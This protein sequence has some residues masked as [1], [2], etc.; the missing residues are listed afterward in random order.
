MNEQQRRAL[1][2]ERCEP[3]DHDRVE[4][5]ERRGNLHGRHHA[6]VG[7]QRVE[8]IVT[9]GGASVH[10]RSQHLV[11]LVCAERIGL[12]PRLGPV[13]RSV[14]AH[15][16]EMRRDRGDLTREVIRREPPLPESIG[17]R[18][19]RGDDLHSLPDHRAEEGHR[20]QRLGDV[21]ELELV[22]AEQAVRRE[23]VDRL[24]HAEEADDAGQ[25]GER[26]VRLRV[27]AS[28]HA[29]ASRWVLPTP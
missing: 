8:L 22:D 19:R 12:D 28:C 21:V 13:V 1:V 16:L 23:R 18:V 4:A 15:D 5:L 14:D 11:D 29:A 7:D 3:T 20:H 24:L 2:L 25:L 17:Q 10:E 26:Q 27:G 6:K 9:R